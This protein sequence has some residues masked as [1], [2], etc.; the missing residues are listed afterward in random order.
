MLRSRFEKQLFSLNEGLLEMAALVEDAI[1]KTGEVIKTGDKELA[2]TV[3]DGDD[4]INRKEKEV[5]SICLRLLLQQQPVASDLRVIS[6]A[7]KMITDLE[8]IGDQSADICDLLLHIQEKTSPSVFAAIIQMAEA[9]SKMVKHSID[10]YIE[11]DVEKA[12]AVIKSDDQIDRLFNEVKTTLM[13]GIK[14]EISGSEDSLDYLM[15]AKY[16]ERIGDHSVNIARRVAFSITGIYPN[17]DGSFP[18]PEGV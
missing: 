17:K 16:F 6:A 1:N 5:E 9:S 10:A 3:I 8:R 2:Q 7:L 4:K 14:K 12:V 11:K 18:D 15:I 13:D